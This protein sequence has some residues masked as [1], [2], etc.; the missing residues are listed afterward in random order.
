[1]KYAPHRPKNYAVWFNTDLLIGK[2]IE[3]KES[4]GLS[5]VD[6]ER[7]TGIPKGSFPHLDSGRI[8]APGA[9]ILCTLM[10]WVGETDL[11]P[12]MIRTRPVEGDE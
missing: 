9:H 2:V 11:A 4:L 1:M 8:S 5:W 3:K 12:Y 10:D 7:L 6:L